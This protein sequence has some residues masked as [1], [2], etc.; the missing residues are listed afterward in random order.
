[1]NA[2]EVIIVGAGLAGLT[3]ALA[4]SRS[5]VSV[6]LIEKNNFP[7]HK[8]CGEYISNE[9]RDYLESF[10][11]DLSDADPIQYLR[12]STAG[13]RMLETSLLRGLWDQSFYPGPQTLETLPGF[14][15]RLCTRK[16]GGF[17]GQYSGRPGVSS[18][19]R[20]GLRSRA[21]G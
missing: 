16:G 7:K 21:Q 2:Y 19:S 8:V 3:A 14:W 4:L 12:F 11:L 10:G 5:G 15:C 13:G 6:A 9:V 20:H 17:A 1:M 18:Q